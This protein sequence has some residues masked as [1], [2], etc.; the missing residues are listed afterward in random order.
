[1]YADDRIILVETIGDVHDHCM[2]SVGRI[3]HNAQCTMM[4]W[5]DRAPAWSI[6]DL[7][8]VDR[9]PDSTELGTQGLVRPSKRWPCWRV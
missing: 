5:L 8:T 4:H 7:N 6:E 1:M 3:L 2:C 9:K